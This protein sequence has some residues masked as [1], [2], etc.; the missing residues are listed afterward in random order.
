MAYFSARLKLLSS[1]DGR[2]SFDS[3]DQFRH[4]IYTAGGEGSPSIRVRRRSRLNFVA[5][6]SSSYSFSSKRK[7]LMDFDN[8]NLG[9]DEDGDD[10][11]FDDELETVDDDL[12]CF[13]GLVLD[14]SYRSF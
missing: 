6:V 13:R 10:W 7:K 8:T 2:F 14:I 12:S 11:S 5:R 3:R 1:S 9:S 4:G